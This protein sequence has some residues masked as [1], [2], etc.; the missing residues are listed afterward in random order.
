MAGMSIAV[1]TLDDPGS[2]LDLAGP[3]L[4]SD[5]VQH[6]LILTLL[7]TRV[8]HPE[9]GRYWMAVEE[10]DVIGVVF[11]SPLDH[12]ATLTPMP[13]EAVRAAVDVIADEGVELPGVSGEAATVAHFAGAWSERTRVPASPTLG[14]RLYEL[15]DV[16]DQPAPGVR[17]RARTEDR[18]FLVESFIAF[19]IEIGE[20]AEGSESVVDRRLA[21]RQL[22]VWD[23]GGAV[24]MCGLT[25]AAEGVVRVGPVYTPPELRGRGYASALV[26]AVSADVRAA[27]T[28]C[29]LY[30]DLQ[31]PTSNLIYR[32]IGYRAVAEVLSYEFGPRRV[33]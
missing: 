22:W 4:A 19:V 6:N 18:E 25:A 14:Q 30:T 27:G 29:I 16:V 3:F 5:P 8:E 33:A 7:R 21:A 24:S 32:N 12:A 17:R 10:H 1:R 31:N 20:P 13:H 28:R 26:S 11:Q 15:A 2:V 9:A 23:D